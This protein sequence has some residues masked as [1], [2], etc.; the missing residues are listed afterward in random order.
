MKDPTEYFGIQTNEGLD[1]MISS[2]MKLHTQKNIVGPGVN[3]SQFSNKSKMQTISKVIE[4]NAKVHKETQLEK[5]KLDQQRNE[6]AASKKLEIQL[7]QQQLAQA[8]NEVLS[9]NVLRGLQLIISENEVEN[10]PQLIAELSKEYG[11]CCIDAP[12]EVPISI[13]VDV[14]TSV[15][16][17]PFDLIFD[18]AE[19][20]SYVRTL[21]KQAFKFKTIWILILMPSK[22]NDMRIN[23]INTALLTF[24]S[25]ISKFPMKL[26]LRQ[27]KLIHL[28]KV[29]FNICKSSSNEAIL[30]SNCCLIEKYVRRPFLAELNNPSF[31]KNRKFLTKF[32]TINSMLAAF[33]SYGLKLYELES[34]SM[35]KI[36][37]SQ[38]YIPVFIH[39]F[40]YN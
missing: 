28:P 7:H 20:K 38:S 22:I 32:P 27:V 8:E 13:I 1:T 31:A 36:K 35:S 33:L 37:Q 34:S 12:L 21:T 10:F 25:A 5:L 40:I 14:N 18:R 2:Y 6:H 4:T 39:N 24:C 16:F 11:I 3:S 30:E 17:L 29:I 19:L 15:S 23:S 26:V 9:N